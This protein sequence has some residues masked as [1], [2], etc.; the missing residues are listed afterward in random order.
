MYGYIHNIA[1]TPQDNYWTKA[2]EIELNN[3]TIVY[4]LEGDFEIEQG[5]GEM[6]T[7][8]NFLIWLSEN[9]ETRRIRING[10]VNH[11]GCWWVRNDGNQCDVHKMANKSKQGGYPR[12]EEKPN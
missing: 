4:G 6:F 8:E 5:K 3:G 10:G 12:F 7:K 11:R 9:R 2:R 1:D